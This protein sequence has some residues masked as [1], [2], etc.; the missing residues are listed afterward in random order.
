MIALKHE[1]QI[2]SNTSA[3]SFDELDRDFR[4]SAR[5]SIARKKPCAP[6][7]ILLLDGHLSG[8]V[9]NFGKGKYDTDSNAI[10]EQTSCVDYDYTYHQIELLNASFNCVV[11]FYV[12]NT[13]PPR[14]REVVWS[15]LA[16]LVRTDGIVFVAVRSNK[17][18]GIKGIPFLDGYISSIGTYQVG[19]TLEKLISEGQRHFKHVD[20]LRNKS[21]FYLIRCSHTPFPE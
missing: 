20:K 3:P 13:L 1:M 2:H 21:G 7:Q 9:L 11:A 10:R 18:K 16:S 14:S 8:S 6:L 12:Q 5:T 17:D 19:Y 4:I 15:R